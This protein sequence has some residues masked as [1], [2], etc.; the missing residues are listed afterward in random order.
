M[1]GKKNVQPPPARPKD[2]TPRDILIPVATDI[3]R[4]LDHQRLTAADDRSGLAELWLESNG[5][6]GK[7]PR[8]E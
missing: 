7:A 3:L 8:W 4:Q 5:R 1:Q 6:Y 2:P